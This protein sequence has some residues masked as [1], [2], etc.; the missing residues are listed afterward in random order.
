MPYAFALLHF[1]R[2]NSGGYIVLLYDDTLF[3]GIYMNVLDIRA[4]CICMLNE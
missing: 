2:Q 1:W 4:R 3:L